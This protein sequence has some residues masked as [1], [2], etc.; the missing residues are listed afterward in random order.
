MPATQ[1]TKIGQK[2]LLKMV[3]FLIFVFGFCLYGLYDAMIAYPN[4]GAN[5]A[6]HRKF[7]YL[8]ALTEQGKR[9]ASVS[10]NPAEELARLKDMQI[11]GPLGPVEQK[12]FE[13]L[14]QL[15]LI[16]KLDTADTRIDDP[17]A[18]FNRLKETWLKSDG[19]K[20]DAAALSWYDI[21]VQWAIFGACG[22][23][24]IWMAV[25]L[26]TVARRKYGW[27]PGEERLYLPDGSSLAPAD[28]AEFDK[29]RW[30]KFLV[31]LKVKPGHAQHGGKEIKLDLFC[32]S[33]LEEWVLAMEKTAFP[34]TAA[35]AA[36]AEQNPPPADPN[37]AGA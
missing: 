10:F 30:D 33:P 25:I 9:F 17:I 11:R 12:K 4:R 27:D 14:E 16:G 34:E 22:I 31:F 3:I 2:W 7:Q 5:A 20:R 32:H 18:E 15:E 29:R 8:D 21:P 37:K 35:A 28:I 1:T 24:S 13:W 6:E 36:P 23:I 19:S 26:I